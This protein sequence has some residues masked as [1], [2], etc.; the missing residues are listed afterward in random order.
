MRAVENFST[1]AMQAAKA[2]KAAAKGRRAKVA[3]C[4]TMPSYSFGA[5]GSDQG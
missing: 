3:L 2:V 1:F 4:Q 5:F